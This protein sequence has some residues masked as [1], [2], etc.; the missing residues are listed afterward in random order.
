MIGV[1]THHWTNKIDIERGKTL[2]N[3]NG[4]AQ[5]KAPGFV[6]RRTLYSRQDSTKITALVLW[7]SE[8]IYECWKSSPERAR[9]MSDAGLLWSRH[10]ESERFDVSD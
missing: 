2:L 7:D 10:P 9:V 1:L 6:S 4:L 8:A 5:S 3:S